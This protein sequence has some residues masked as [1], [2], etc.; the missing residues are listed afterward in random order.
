MLER[1]L[2]Q[3]ALVPVVIESAV[4]PDHPLRA[5]L[6]PEPE[7]KVLKRCLLKLR[8]SFCCL[9][10]HSV[11]FSHEG[12]IGI[13]LLLNFELP[14]HVLNLVRKIISDGVVPHQ[15]VEES[16]AFR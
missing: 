2:L 13:E 4:L 16:L 8:R 3:W 9:G 5:N 11:D 14:H 10:E 6:L 15:F 7:H 1:R 12:D